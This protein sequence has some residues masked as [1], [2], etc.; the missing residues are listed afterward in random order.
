MRFMTLIK[1]AESANVGSPPPE[2]FQ[3]ISRLGDEAK[4]AG[5][6]VET[7]GL[8][9]TAAGARVRLD[10]GQDSVGAYAIFN[11]GSKQEAIGWAKRFME[12]HREYWSGWQGETE[13][14]QLIEQP[15]AARAPRA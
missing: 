8:M 7:A 5:V 4:Q 14:R 15:P 3:A 11:V 12:L 10:G 1:S 9:P 2:L 13:V 6:L